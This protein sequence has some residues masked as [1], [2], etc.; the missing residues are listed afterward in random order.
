MREE[1]DLRVMEEHLLNWPQT[2]AGRRTA[3]PRQPLP[4]CVTTNGPARIAG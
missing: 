2:A 4:D 1:D 3:T